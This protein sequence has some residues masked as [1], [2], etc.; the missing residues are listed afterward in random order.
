MENLLC[1]AE[2]AIGT[3]NNR[4]DSTEP[5]NDAIGFPSW[6]CSLASKE[7]SGEAGLQGA[8]FTYCTVRSVRQRFS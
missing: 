2:E 1:K 3:R 8:P 5:S 7:E 4:I 6:A